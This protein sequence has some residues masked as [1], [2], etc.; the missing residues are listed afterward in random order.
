MKV[1]RTAVRLFSVLAMALAPMAYA[2]PEE[3]AVTAHRLMIRSGLSVQLRGF[4]AHIQR[5]IKQNP[6]GLDEKMVAALSDAAKEAFRADL[7]QED[8]TARVAKKITVGDMKAALT[9]LD[10]D[11]GQRVTLAEELSSAAFDQKRFLEYT[12]DLNAKPLLNKRKKLMSEL[13][14]ATNAVRAV[15]ATQEAIA[16]GIAIGMDSLQPKE[17]R[18]GEAALRGRV[19]E[20]MQPEKL[21][22]A[23]AQQ[24]PVLFAYEYREV[25]DDDLAGYV[26]FLKTAAGKRY[27]DGMTGAF[28]E[29]LGRA[30]VQ[31]GE[32]A[33]QRQ[34]QTAM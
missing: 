1:E 27:Q 12:E 33:G 28:I 29:G 22:A 15:A 23:L 18:V 10:T 32:L 9:W 7:L 2:Q 6:A 21:Q 3:A 16:L 5:E 13:V 30:A 17:R 26:G 14:S 19:R 8:M 34:R 20:M 4:T 24:L 11:A 31:V 25:S